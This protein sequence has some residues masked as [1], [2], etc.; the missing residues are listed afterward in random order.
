[1]DHIRHRVEVG[2]RE[3]VLRFV[4]WEEV[5]CVFSHRFD[6]LEEMLSDSVVCVVGGGAV[7][8]REGFAEGSFIF[9]EDGQGGVD[10]RSGRFGDDFMLEFGMLVA[11]VLE[12][13]PHL[14]GGEG[15]EESR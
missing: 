15:L 4:G 6:E 12:K 7:A 3:A 10:G 5:R 14:V 1:M 8:E 13:L 9:A 11:D 2:E